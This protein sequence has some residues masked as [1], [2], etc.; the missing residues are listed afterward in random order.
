ML[1]MNMFQLNLYYAVNL[2][3][4]LCPIVDVKAEF[5]AIALLLYCA[6]VASEAIFSYPYPVMIWR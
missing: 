3:N 2:K 5:D 6:I 4:P 1:I